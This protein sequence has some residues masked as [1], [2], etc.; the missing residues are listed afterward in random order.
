MIHLLLIQK[1][2]FI[3]KLAKFPLFTGIIGKKNKICDKKYYCITKTQCLNNGLSLIEIT[4]KN[5][6]LKYRI[7]CLIIPLK[8]ENSKKKERQKK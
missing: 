8:N 1:K 6:V 4:N 7:I 5:C 2:I 3:F